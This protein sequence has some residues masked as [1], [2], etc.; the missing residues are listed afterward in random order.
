[1][2]RQR[3]FE[4]IGKD[5][6]TVMEKITFYVQVVQHVCTF[7]N[8]P[9]IALSIYHIRYSSLLYTLAAKHESSDIVRC[10]YHLD[11]NSGAVFGFFAARCIRSHEAVYNG[12]TQAH[13]PGHEYQ[14]QKPHE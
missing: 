1:M 14:E 4:C 9:Q 3:F 11:Q 6:F 2:Y 5:F 12:S 10:L 7:H 13:P 8:T